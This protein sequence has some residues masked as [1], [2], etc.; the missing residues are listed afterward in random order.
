MTARATP[1]AVRTGIDR[2]RADFSRLDQAA[3]IAQIRRLADSGLD[4]TQLVKC[5]GWSLADVRRALDR[6]K[7]DMA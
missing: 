6:C 3:A 7:G 1:P 5:T 2:V 4:E